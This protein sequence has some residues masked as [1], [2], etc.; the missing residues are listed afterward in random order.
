M[1][2]YEK[3]IEI[4]I[5]YEFPGSSE[6]KCLSSFPTSTI[7]CTKTKTEKQTNATKQ[8]HVYSFWNAWYKGYKNVAQKC[9]F[10]RFILQVDLLVQSFEYRLL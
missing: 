2:N 1:K 6:L 3:P 9:L 4:K 5:E 7:E 10:F 8:L